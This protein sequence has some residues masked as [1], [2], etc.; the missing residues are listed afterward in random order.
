MIYSYLLPNTFK[1]P[2]WTAVYH[3][4]VP[5]GPPGWRCHNWLPT[6]WLTDWLTDELQEL[7][8]LLLATKNCIF[9]AQI[10]LK[11]FIPFDDS[12]FRS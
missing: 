1:T 11:R 7:L 12:Q 8:K 2:A 6:E 5:F 9:T 10:I 4:L 3:S